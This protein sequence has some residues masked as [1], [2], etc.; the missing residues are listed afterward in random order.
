MKLIVT[1]SQEISSKFAR[2]KIQIP[3]CM[4]SW[5][6]YNNVL[7]SP[8]KCFEISKQTVVTATVY[9]MTGMSCSF[10]NDPLKSGNGI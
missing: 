4:K 10:A 7:E 3:N 6:K 5:K 2:E 1:E 8:K 9:F